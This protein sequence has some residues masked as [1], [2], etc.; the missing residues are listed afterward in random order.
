MDALRAVRGAAPSRRRG[1]GRRRQPGARAARRR[2]GARA[3]RRGHRAHRRSSPAARSRRPRRRRSRAG[4]ARA[5]SRT[6][7]LVR[8]GPAP[9]GDVQAA[10]R[11][12]RYRLLEAWC[13]R[14]GVLHL[15]TAHHREDQAET[16][17]LRLARG[18]GL[19]GLAGIAAATSSAPP[20]ACCGRF[21]A[22]RGRGSPRRSRRAARTGSR[23]RAT[24]TRPTR[25]RGCA[26]LAPVLAE[27][28][29]TAERLADTARRLGRA[30]AALE[31][32]VAA[33]LARA[34]WLDPA[35]FAWLDPI[36]AWRRARR[37]R[38]A[39]ARRGTRLCRRH[40]LSA[41]PRRHRAAA[42]ANCAAAC[43]QA[44]T[45]GGC[46]VAAAAPAGAG[47]PRARGLGAARR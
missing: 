4:S 37:D 6:R 16:L 45:L 14:A 10:A 20:A 17:L 22:W 1:V 34:A 29:L 2:L 5:A 39:G 11:A 19:D 23:I 3:G 42:G 32:E 21:S 7:I 36:A 30:R 26:A 41:A 43:P 13:A 9:Q 46:V 38:A 8:D 27:Q 31:G 12:A 24:A 28:G 47:L 40:D 15:L 25:A 44:R 18:S 35:G 33:L